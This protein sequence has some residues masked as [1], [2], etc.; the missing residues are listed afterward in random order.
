[1]SSTYS[2]LIQDPSNTLTHDEVKA[3]LEHRLAEAKSKAAT[4]AVLD[5]CAQ[6]FIAEEK[7]TDKRKAVAMLIQV[8]HLMSCIGKGLVREKYTKSGPGNPWGFTHSHST[9]PRNALLKLLQKHRDP[10]DESLTDPV[11]FDALY[12]FKNCA[13][14]GEVGRFQHF[15]YHDLMG[16][17]YSARD[18]TKQEFTHALNGRLPKDILTLQAFEDGAAGPGPEDTGQS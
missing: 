16:L 11:L 12:G 5:E 6:E 13:N 9:T 8:A 15:T 17:C 7:H 1:M 3:I 14:L 10:I 18:M 4:A 2:N